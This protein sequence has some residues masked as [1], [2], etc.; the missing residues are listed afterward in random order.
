MKKIINKYNMSVINDLKLYLFIY[1]NLQI[2][3]L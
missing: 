3:K 2:V 1:D